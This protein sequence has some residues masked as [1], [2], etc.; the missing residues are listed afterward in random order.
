MTTKKQKKTAVSAN[1]V[2]DFILAKAND[3][4]DL[5]TNLKLQKLVYYAQAWYLANR[6]NELFEEDFEAWVHGPVIPELYK[7]YKEFGPRPIIKEL[8]L[9]NVEKKFSKDT[10]DFLNEFI[11]V[12]MA[13]TAYQ[14]ELMVHQEEPWVEARKGY[15][16]D[17]NCKEIII[18]TKIKR[19]YGQKI[20]DKTD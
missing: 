14:L 5:I 18:K 17:E 4:E 11:R 20:K 2:A 19:F 16:P 13:Y 8:Q 1:D 10:L 15:A 7:K 6:S 9:K 3:S 12:Y